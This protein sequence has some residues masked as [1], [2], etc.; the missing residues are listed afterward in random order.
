MGGFYFF[1][2]LAASFIAGISLVA[3]GIQMVY[4]FIGR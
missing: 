1:G 3:A 2:L 4:K